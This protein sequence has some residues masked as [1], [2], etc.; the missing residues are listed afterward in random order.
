ML[1]WFA[2]SHLVSVLTGGGLLKLFFGNL[3]KDLGAVVAFLRAHSIW[4]SV[5]GALLILCLI[6]FSALKLEQ[7]HSAKLDRQLRNCAEVQRRL[8]EQSKAQ[9]KQVGKVID[10]Y[11]TVDRPVIRK[12][13]QRIESAPLKGNCQTPDLVMG[14][15]V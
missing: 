5:S 11:I 2:A 1:A 3:V 6:E 15:D 7:R 10:H 9:Q 4:L 13:V 8:V 12:E 14:A